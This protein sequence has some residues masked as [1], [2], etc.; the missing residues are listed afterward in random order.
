M[1]PALP[2]DALRRYSSLPEDTFSDT[3]SQY[4][5]L[6]QDQL[7]Q[8]P[9]S[10]ERDNKLLRFNP[11][12]VNYSLLD[13][14]YRP[15]P[16]PSLTALLQ[17]SNFFI[18]ESQWPSSAEASIPPAELTCYR[19]NIFQVVGSITLPRTMHYIVTEQ[20]ERI[21]IHAKELSISATESVEGH[22]VKII[23]VPWKTSTSTA[24]SIP[25]EKIEMEPS[26][27]VLDTMTNQDTDPDY[28][29]FPIAWKRLQFRIATANNGRRKEL[30][31]HFVIRL[32]VIATLETGN[33]V[34]IC[35]TTSCPII[36]RGRS[37]RNFQQRKDLP[38]TGPGSSMR[39]AAMQPPSLLTRSSSGESVTRQNR[40]KNEQSPET[41]LES[42]Q[43]SPPANQNTQNTSSHN[44]IDWAQIPRGPSSS[45]T[46]LPTP[47]FTTTI[48]VNTP[49]LPAYAH[50]SPDL[51][52]Q[53][54]ITSHPSDSQ[55]LMLSLTDSPP[56]ASKRTRHFKNP[57]RTSHPPKSTA[58]TSN[59]LAASPSSPLKKRPH[60]T[61]PPV[62]ILQSQLSSGSGIGSDA[63][64]LL[65]EY[66]PLGLDDWMPPV[67]AV[68]RPHVVHHTNL[69]RE[70]G[71]GKVA[72]VA[73]GKRL[74]SE[75]EA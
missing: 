75:C 37:P 28:A 1:P 13:Y 4:D 11:P 19:R 55:P 71:A 58:T 47:T 24:T 62:S 41:P 22:T 64:D 56:P 34:L 25:E 10:V 42:F 74:Y 9:P 16:F 63:A 60:S 68:Y 32:K 66:F 69:P 49:P 45:L 57:R 18:A 65:Y 23:T 43:Y 14:S 70:A 20:G 50:S 52:R 2:Y 12:T 39:K 21:A 46:A 38:I 27:M 51:A 33:K 40:L 48:A 17:G 35:E 15:I 8:E 26:P 31:Q 61:P 73:R 44:L 67:D 30:Q 3:A 7:V 29:T 5:S 59:P 6:P 72:S 54:T 36:V 53:P